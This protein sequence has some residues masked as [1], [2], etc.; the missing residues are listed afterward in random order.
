MP[1]SSQLRK[2]VQIKQRHKQINKL[3]FLVDRRGSSGQ[4][5]LKNVNQTLQ[6]KSNITIKLKAQ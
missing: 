5:G 3:Y 2:Y 4:T 6:T 1:L